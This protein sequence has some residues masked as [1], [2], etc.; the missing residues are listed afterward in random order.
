MLY[1]SVAVK[2]LREEYLAAGGARRKELEQ[3]YGRK[4][5]QKLVEDSF[6]EDWLSNNAKKCPHCAAHIEVRKKVHLSVCPSVV[7]SVTLMDS[8]IAVV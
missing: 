4:N 6:S 8:V 2:E 5:I 3:R 7:L 1:I